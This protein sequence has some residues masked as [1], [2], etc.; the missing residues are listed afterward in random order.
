M[1]LVIIIKRNIFKT[2][3][4]DNMS[5][6]AESYH[7]ISTSGAGK[8]KMDDFDGGNLFDW[9]LSGKRILKAKKLHRTLEADF[10]SSFTTV[11]PSSEDNEERARQVLARNKEIEELEELDNT[12]LCVVVASLN[13]EWKKKVRHCKTT[14][15]VVSTIRNLVEKNLPSTI[16]ALSN[17]LGTK[18]YAGGDI[19]AHIAVLDDLSDRLE[20]LN[21]PVSDTDKINH[22]MTSIARNKSFVE[23]INDLRTEI[24]LSN[25]SKNPMTYDEV[26]ESLANDES[27]RRSVGQASIDMVN[28]VSN[29]SWGRGQR[30]RG[31]GGRIRGNRRNSAFQA[32]HSGRNNNTG[33]I[34]CYH[35]L[36]WTDPLPRT[37]L[38]PEHLEKRKTMVMIET[39]EITPGADTRVIEGITP[40][41]DIRVIEGIMP[42]ADFKLLEQ[43]DTPG[44]EILRELIRLT[45]ISE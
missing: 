16:M 28:H 43:V 32:S 25:R 3:I 35:C 6:Q 37:A 38:S 42:G 22:L 33:H 44:A 24:K 10:H 1:F 45:L 8:L 29:R 27:F 26:K 15:S 19:M 7:V 21:K 23:R 13:R 30:G 34:K 11:E 12:A 18:V 17:E 14:Y 2:T 36:Q 4:L 39:T 20:A 40:G 5:E 41:A 9:E 31:R